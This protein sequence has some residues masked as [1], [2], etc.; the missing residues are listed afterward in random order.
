MLNKTYNYIYLLL[1]IIFISLLFTSCS[2]SNNSMPTSDNKEKIHF[3]FTIQDA[4]SK[5]DS[6]IIDAAKQAIMTN[7]HS[8]IESLYIDI[9]EVKEIDA[10]TWEVRFRDKVNESDSYELQS[11]CFVTVEKQQSGKYEGYILNPSA[12]FFTPT[13]APK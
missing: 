2:N 10:K 4:A 1:N 3:T 9:F 11:F 12:P 8:E 13:S 6:A 7:D 5:Y